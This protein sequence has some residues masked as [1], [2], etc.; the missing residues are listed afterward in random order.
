[1]LQ[2]NLFRLTLAPCKRFHFHQLVK[3]VIDLM[4]GAIIASL[5]GENEN[6]VAKALRD[7]VLCRKLN[8]AFGIERIAK[9]D[10]GRAGTRTDRQSP[11]S[12]SQGLWNTDRIGLFC[13]ADGTVI[14]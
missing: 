13:A 2:A 5:A 12:K 4:P 8:S 11:D 1:M 9:T 6:V 3:M 14:D 7:A 10:A